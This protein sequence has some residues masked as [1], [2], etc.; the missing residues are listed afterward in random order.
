MGGAGANAIVYDAARGPSD[1]RVTDD[2][3]RVLETRSAGS[4]P[5]QSPRSALAGRVIQDAQRGALGGA[6]RLSSEDGIAGSVKGLTV[7]QRL[8]L[9]G[10]Q[11]PRTRQHSRSS[12]RAIEKSFL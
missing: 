2:G 9:A 5:G 4:G 8:A 11:R 6:G 3:G 7:A 12:T 10:K 1:N